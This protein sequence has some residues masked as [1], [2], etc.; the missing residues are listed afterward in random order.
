[1]RRDPTPR[2]SPRRCV[3]I[4]PVCGQACELTA[5]RGGD[6]AERATRRGLVAI[7]GRIDREDAE[8][9][10]ADRQ[11]GAQRR[12]A[13]AIRLRVELA[14]EAG[15]LARGEAEGRPPRAGGAAPRGPAAGGRRS[16]FVRGGVRSGFG[17][18]RG[19]RH[20]RRRAGVGGGG[21][22]RAPGTGCSISVSN[23]FAV[24][25][26][27]C[28]QPIGVGSPTAARSITAVSSPSPQSITLSRVPELAKIVSLPPSAR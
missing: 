21:R 23:S 19:R 20:H 6:D 26:R 24:P 2:P 25:S 12:V 3:R 1:M 11:V 7:S 15:A 9:V 8:G 13:A 28:S 17:F 18:G 16:S 5:V 14:L 10:A 27:T 4:S 22:D